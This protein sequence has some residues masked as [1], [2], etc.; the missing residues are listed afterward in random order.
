M[1]KSFVFALHA[2]R[3]LVFDALHVT[4]QSTHGLVDML[5]ES[6]VSHWLA[7]NWC[8]GHELIPVRV[9]KVSLSDFVKNSI[10][11]TYHIVTCFE[12]HFF[13][14]LFLKDI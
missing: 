6:P 10:L 12:K 5:H 13:Y 4:D 9:Q 3:I 8:G 11:V 2:T 1:I 14:L 7:F